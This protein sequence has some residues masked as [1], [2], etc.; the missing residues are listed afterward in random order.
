MLRFLGPSVASAGGGCFAT[1]FACVFLAGVGAGTEAG[2]EAGTGGAGTGTGTSTT[3][4]STTG[5]FFGA[6]VVLIYCFLFIIITDALALYRFMFEVHTIAVYQKEFFYTT[7][8]VY[9]L[10]A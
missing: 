1:R 6:I 2:T 10:A 5:A 7:M 3:G 9:I 4:V 8:I